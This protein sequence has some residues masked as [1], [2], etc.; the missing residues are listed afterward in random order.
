MLAGCI[1]VPA[2]QNPVN[3]NNTFSNQ[4]G[5][6]Q[7]MKSL[8]IESPVFRS[9]EKIP[10]RFT[11]D[12]E[13]INPPLT[14]KNIPA[15]AKSLAVIM[16]DPDAPMG[17]WDHWIIWNI[18][19]QENIRENSQ[20]GVEG[21]NSWNNNEYGG[22][23]PPSG[24]HRYFFKVYALDKMLSLSPSSKKKDVVAAI[25]GHVIASG[26]LVGMYR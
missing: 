5:E 8:L 19:I 24:S 13:G 20:P 3:I 21:R 10:S 1:A 25:S 17:T 23:C 22:P 2:G 7:N 9:M 4:T 12:G 14:I 11:C 16:D 15:E 18:P 6:V 26:Q